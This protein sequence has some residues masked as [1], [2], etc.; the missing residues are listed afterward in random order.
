MDF[1]ANDDGGIFPIITRDGG[2]GF[3]FCPGKATWYPDVKN[4]FDLMVLA[5]ETGQ[6]ILAGALADQPGWAVDELSWFVPEYRETQFMRRAK[7]IFGSKK[8]EPKTTGAPH[9][10]KPR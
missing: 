10:H 1:T 4:F 2:P 7:A 9:A 6:P 8:D 5:A 3:G